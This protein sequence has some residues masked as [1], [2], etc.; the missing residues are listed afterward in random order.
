MSYA[1]KNEKQF[2]KDVDKISDEVGYISKCEKPECIFY[3]QDKIVPEWFGGTS[4]ISA[5]VLI[6]L[7]CTHQIHKDHYL[8]KDFLNGN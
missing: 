1:P 7:T 8:H 2:R 6:C 5:N 4:M 3:A